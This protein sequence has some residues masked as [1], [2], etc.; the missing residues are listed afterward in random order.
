MHLAAIVKKLERTVFPKGTIIEV[1]VLNSVECFIV[2]SETEIAL[3]EIIDR[4]TRNIYSI[5]Y[6]FKANN[7]YFK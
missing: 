1:R 7:F 6:F 5:L 2:N 4:V 3:G